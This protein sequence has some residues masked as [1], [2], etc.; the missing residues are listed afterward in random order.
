MLGSSVQEGGEGWLAVSQRHVLPRQRVRANFD[1][2]EVAGG[3]R[4]VQRAQPSA[5]ACPGEWRVLMVSSANPPP[6]RV[7]ATMGM[8]STQASRHASRIKG[9][10]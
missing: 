5:I 1:L 10:R 8:H 2:E 4:M 7:S 6:P 9:W 3:G